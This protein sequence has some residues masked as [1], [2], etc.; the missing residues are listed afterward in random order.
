MGGLAKTALLVCGF[1][2]EISD[3]DISACVSGAALACKEAGVEIL[4]GHTVRIAEPIFGLAA[5][6]YVNPGEIWRKTGMADGDL[7][8]LSKPLGVGVLLS[9]R[10]QGDEEIAL[11]QMKVSNLGARNSLA[12]LG[13]AVHA[14]TDVTGFGLIGHLSEMLGNSFLNAQVQVPSQAVL[15]QAQSLFD[16]GKRTSADV[17]NRAALDREVLG[18]NNGNSQ[19]ALFDPQTNGG[20]LASIDPEFEIQLIER[21]FITVGKVVI[22]SGKIEILSN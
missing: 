3:E 1:P 22:G 2:K 5:T 21:G 16:S 10:E 17:R 4:G 6:G 19:A 11:N 12:K 18:L 8:M 14:V 9:T 13:S 15:P 20:L 7:L